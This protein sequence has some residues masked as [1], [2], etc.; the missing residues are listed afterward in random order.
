MLRHNTALE[1][2]FLARLRTASQVRNDRL[3]AGGA[4]GR[5][6]DIFRR[7]VRG[8]RMILT[9]ISHVFL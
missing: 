4:R 7:F 3:R 6:E 5:A 8:K 9:L 1:E 2:S